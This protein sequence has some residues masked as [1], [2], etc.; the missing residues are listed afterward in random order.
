M[1]ENKSFSVLD[2]INYIIIIAGLLFIVFGFIAMSGGGTDDPNVF[3]GD[4]L[5]DFRRLTLSTILILIG[6]A[7]EIVGILYHRKQ[8]S[9]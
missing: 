1:K 5:F 3:A 7:L 9:K 6:F 8:S 2:K 4:T